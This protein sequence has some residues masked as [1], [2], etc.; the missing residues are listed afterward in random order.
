VTQ[1]EEK[2]LVTGMVTIETGVVTISIIF[3]FYMRVLFLAIDCGKRVWH[4]QSQK[5]RPLATHAT[6]SPSGL[7]TERPGSKSVRV[8]FD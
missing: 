7:G 5:K 6:R 8:R 3:V 2:K 4:E 1:G